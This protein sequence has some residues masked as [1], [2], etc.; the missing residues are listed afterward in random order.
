MVDRLALIFDA[1]STYI[2]IKNK[3]LAGLMN[4]KTL[5]LAFYEIGNCVVQE[6]RMKIID[7]KASL[8]LLE[9][10][11]NLPEIMSASSFKELESG[12]IFE[13]AERLGLTF[14]D[15]SYIVLAQGTKEALVTND[16]ALAKA[17]RKIG[18]GIYSATNYQN[19]Q[20]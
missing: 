3:N 7:E 10:L 16:G 20:L 19:S 17:A 5:D 1:S 14:Y 13:I 6:R 11:D 2:L 8:A 9:A 15:A 4:S 18:I 12:K